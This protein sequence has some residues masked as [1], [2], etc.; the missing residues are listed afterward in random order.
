LEGAW[1]GQTEVE[2]NS[3]RNLRKKTFDKKMT[4]SSSLK[5]VTTA[6]SV[7]ALSPALARDVRQ[8][9]FRPSD[10]SSV[11]SEVSEAALATGLQVSAADRVAAADAQR[12]LQSARD[13]DDVLGDAKSV[14]SDD[15]GGLS[16]TEKDASDAQSTVADSDLDSASGAEDGAEDED[17][18][19]GAVA[20]VRYVRRTDLVRGDVVHITWRPLRAITPLRTPNAH[21]I[22]STTSSSSSVSSERPSQPPHHFDSSS[23]KTNNGLP[24]TVLLADTSLSPP[25]SITNAAK[26]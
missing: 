6:A 15:D 5:D 8:S 9:M 3:M 13:L 20:L 19:D 23:L 25:L 21:P 2:H 11:H 10:S 16:A 12:Q 26:P 22:Q 14:V 18:G 17:H 4:S 24:S 7:S 1:R